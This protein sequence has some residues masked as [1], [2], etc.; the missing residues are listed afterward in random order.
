M[1]EALQ[2]WKNVAGKEGDG[3]S[4]ETKSV[5]HGECMQFFELLLFS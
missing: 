2:L 1:N 3:N 4:E 5:S